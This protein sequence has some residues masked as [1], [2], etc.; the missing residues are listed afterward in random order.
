MKRVVKD[1]NNSMADYVFYQKDY[2]N[3]PNIK[4]S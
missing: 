2:Y 1:Q 4:N 3:E